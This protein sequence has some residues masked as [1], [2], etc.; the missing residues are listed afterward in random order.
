MKTYVWPPSVRIFHWLLAISFT[1]AYLLRDSGEYHRFHR[2]FG[3]MIGSLIVLRLFYGFIGTPYTRFS[4]FRIGISH[5]LY[6]IKSFF[7]KQITYPGHNPLAGLTLLA[8]LL[9]G[10]LAGTSGFLLYSTATGRMHLSLNR[11][12]LHEGHEILASLFLA[13][14]L[15]HITGLVV[16]AFLHPAEKTVLSMFNGKKNVEGTDY[17][18]TIL[19]KW[20]GVVWMGVSA[21]V[22]FVSL[23]YL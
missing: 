4:A 23:R 14:V 12:V 21:I 11:S 8:V 1:A 9:V 15:V 2:A 20:Y 22:F 19:Q 6:F 5:Q 18:T 7:R 16:D 3:L 10:L 13:L 17:Q